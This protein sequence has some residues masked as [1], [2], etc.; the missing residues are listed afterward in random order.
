MSQLY[1][2]RIN[3]ARFLS[4]VTDFKSEKELSKFI[5]QFAIDLVTGNSNSDYAT[6]VISEAIEYI[7]KKKK[8]G[9]M[10]GKQKS[11]S[12]RAV[13]E[14][15]QSSD[16]ALLKQ[17]S[18]KGLANNN[19]SNNNNIETKE[20]KKKYAEK[21][22]MT[23]KQ[24]QTLLAKHGD[25]KTKLFIEKLSISKC[26]NNKM[27]YTSDYHAIL[28]WVIDAVEKN[29]PKVMQKQELYF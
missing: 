2:Y 8:A 27:T 11:S 13:L 17:K 20:E 4:V 18:S 14:Q 1:F 21:V 5:N 22:L 29:N 16:K 23:E 3:A 6:E 10:G 12:A 15:C 9:S 26:A 25:Q 7:K 28:K 19:S 24:Y